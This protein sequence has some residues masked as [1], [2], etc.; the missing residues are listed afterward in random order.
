M[1]Q[2]TSSDNWAKKETLDRIAKASERSADYLQDMLDSS[3]RGLR[4]LA[5][6]TTQSASSTRASGR[7]QQETGE[8]TK[9]LGKAIGNLYTTLKNNANERERT[10]RAA[11]EF[12]TSLSDSSTMFRNATTRVTTAVSSLPLL[13]P[14]IGVAIGAITG[15]VSQ[16]L[17]TKDTFMTMVDSGIMFDGSISGFRV[18]VGNAGLT[19]EEFATLVE[20]SGQAIKVFGENKFLQS[21]LRLR[22]TF[23]DLGISITQGNEYFAEYLENSRLSNNLYFRTQAE[24]EQGFIDNLKLMKEQARLTG[25]T[26]RQQRD[27]QRELRQS[28]EYQLMI[29]SLSPSR[30]TYIES[31]TNAI[32]PVAGADFAREFFTFVETRAPV[33]GGFLQTTQQFGGGQQLQALAERARRG[34]QLSPEDFQNAIVAIPEHVFGMALR[35][36]RGSNPQLAERLMALRLP[37]EK[38]AFNRARARGPNAPPTGISPEVQLLTAGQAALKN[39]LSQFQSTMT[40]LGAGLLGLVIPELTTFTNV[41]RTFNSAPNLQTAL[42][43]LETGGDLSDSVKEILASYRTGGLFSA[44]WTAI[45][46]AGTT[47]GGLIWL[48]MDEGW[49]LVKTYF[50]DWKNSLIESLG[51]WASNLVAR[52]GRLRI[53]GM[54]IGGRETEEPQM[55][56]PEERRANL[57]RSTTDNSDVYVPRLNPLSERIGQPLNSFPP[58]NRGVVQTPTS[59]GQVVDTPANSTLATLAADTNRM[60][61]E[62]VTLTQQSNSINEKIQSASDANAR[63]TVDAISMGMY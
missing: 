51:T 56:T 16:L 1:S 46:Q 57:A 4:S 26:V 54:R 40:G 19:A 60:L 31:Q 9:S 50:T 34:E 23:D 52:L 61:S 10:G 47:I 30:R 7:A 12:G 41:M 5:N 63:R 21:T 22:Q 11:R 33:A 18:A 43:N 58:I 8:K 45:R 35:S 59:N 36:L 48:G 17:S 42:A 55:A 32:T 20:Q 14:V 27:Q 29:R 62:L 53:F 3:N 6:A 44:A 38:A 37:A 28:L 25:V 39:T 15:L 49:K 24:H 13:G 2:T